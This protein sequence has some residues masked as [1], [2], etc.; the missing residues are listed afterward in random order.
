MC[1][2][3]N[4]TQKLFDQFDVNFKS[5]LEISKKFKAFFE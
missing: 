3:Y 1:V 5:L 4:N 2:A